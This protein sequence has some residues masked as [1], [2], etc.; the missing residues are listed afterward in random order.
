MDYCFD[1]LFGIWG[2]GTIMDIIFLQV[3][4]HGRVVRHY[5]CYDTGSISYISE[6]V[7][8]FSRGLSSR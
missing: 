6:L 1:R 4:F 7:L 2:E 8:F 3:G 5:Y